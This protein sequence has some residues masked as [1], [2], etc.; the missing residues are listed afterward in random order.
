MSIGVQLSFY[1]H[2][3][4]YIYMHVPLEVAKWRKPQEKFGVG[5]I[6][7]VKEKD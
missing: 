7:A 6:S 5:N 1:T 3:E 4:I 2:I